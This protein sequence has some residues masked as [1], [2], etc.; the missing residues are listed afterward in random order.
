MEKEERKFFHEVEKGKIAR[1]ERKKKME[2]KTTEKE[3]FVKKYFPSCSSSPGGTQRLV[4]TNPTDVAYAGNR[5]VGK[6][7]DLFSEDHSA[8]NFNKFAS[9][10]N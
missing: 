4:V 3:N 9:M 1:E 6:V 2:I 10:A 8:I 5:R 7:S